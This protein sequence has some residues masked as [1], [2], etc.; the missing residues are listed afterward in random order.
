MRTS[1]LGSHLHLAEGAAHQRGPR[2]SEHGRGRRRRAAP[3]LSARVLGRSPRNRFAAAGARRSKPSARGEETRRRPSVS[4]RHVG[5][6][7]RPFLEPAD[8]VLAR[9]APQPCGAARDNT[10]ETWKFSQ[11]G[12]DER[13]CGE[14]F[15]EGASIRRL[16]DARVRRAPRSATSKCFARICNGGGVGGWWPPSA[17]PPSPTCSRSAPSAAL[18]GARAPAGAGARG[19][20]VGRRRNVRTRARRVRAHAEDD[21]GRAQS[22]E[23]REVKRI[24][25]SWRRALHR[26]APALSFS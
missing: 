21:A 15:R 13:A 20:A 14:R 3:C 9:R 11:R 16:R 18:C 25:P 12:R 10:R 23:M 6:R 22:E 1:T 24:P 19:G 5:V 7:V 2:P 26:L 4:P 8:L 17:P